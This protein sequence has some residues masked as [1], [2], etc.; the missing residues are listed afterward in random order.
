MRTLPQLLDDQ[1]RLLSRWRQSQQIQSESAARS[2]SGSVVSPLQF[3]KV[4]SVIPTDP[5]YGAHL[6]VLV[7]TPSGNPPVWQDASR[8]AIRA[9]PAPGMSVTEFSADQ[10]V[11]VYFLNGI[12]AA[13]PT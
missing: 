5:T 13:E 3:G 12:I 2:A 10:I 4:Q 9:Y 1:D 11:R 8:P 7:Q 6:L